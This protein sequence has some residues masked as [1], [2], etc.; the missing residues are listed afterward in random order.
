MDIYNLFSLHVR[1]RHPHRVIYQTTYDIPRC[2]KSF[3]ISSTLGQMV[4]H[5]IMVLN[6]LNVLKQWDQNITFGLYRIKRAAS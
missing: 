6:I 1:I 3:V 2:A 4:W 5:S